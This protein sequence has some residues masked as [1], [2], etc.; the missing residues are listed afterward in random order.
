MKNIVIDEDY[1]IKNST[2]PKLRFY[3]PFNPNMSS[4]ANLGFNAGT[5]S[6]PVD[7]DPTATHL[8]LED[9]Q[10]FYF[11]DLFEGATIRIKNAYVI[12]EV[13]TVTITDR[14]ILTNP[15]GD[16]IQFDD[17]LNPL[18]PSGVYDTEIHTDAV[19]VE[20]WS[21]G[22]QTF[23]SSLDEHYGTAALGYHAKWVQGEGR[24]GGSCIK[25]VDQN[26]ILL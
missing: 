6:P 14:N 23:Q 22:V 16:T 21:S 15:S 11:K 2:E 4:T 19:V 18:K 7:D 26:L 8:I 3:N 13:E 1:R 10:G 20:A 5:G 25:F 24:N 17:A 9:G 12:G